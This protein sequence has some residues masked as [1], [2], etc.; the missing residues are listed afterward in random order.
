AKPVDLG[1]EQEQG[2]RDGD[3][4]S[5]NLSRRAF[6]VGALAAP[7]LLGARWQAETDITGTTL[8][9]LAAVNDRY[10]AI[11]VQG[12]KYSREQLLR[13]M[14]TIEPLLDTTLRARSRRDLYQILARTQLLARAGGTT[15]ER[16]T[17]TERA[18]ASAQLC[19]DTYLQAAVYGHLGQF[20]TF[21]LDHPAIGQH[22]L[23]L[24]LQLARGDRL[25]TSWIAAQR[26][27]AASRL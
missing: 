22:Y 13:H 25:L 15:A 16:L 21:R 12:L 24:A 26:A 2:A 9:T 10:R 5:D 3:M 14:A 18:L 27:E 23:G 6:L 8:E 11:Q 4:A 17:L 20:Y 1:F 19:G 7:I